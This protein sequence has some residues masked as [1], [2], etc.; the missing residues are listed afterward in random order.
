MNTREPEWPE[1][2]IGEDEEPLLNEI[3]DKL[4]ETSTHEAVDVADYED[5]KGRVLRKMKRRRILYFSVGSGVAAAM[6]G[7]FLLFSGENT[8]LQPE[9]YGR[10]HAEKKGVRNEVVLTSDNGMQTCLDSMVKI[11]NH[12]GKE[13]ALFMASGKKISVEKGR[14]LRVEVP[15]G[16][17]FQLTLADGSE[18][19]LNAGSS[20]EYPASF[21]GAEERRVQLEGEAF[22]EVRRDTVHPF[23]VEFGKRESIRVL[24]TSFN[25]NA[26][27]DSPVHTTTLVSGKI[28]YMAQ[29]IQREVVLCPDQQVCLDCE[30]GGVNVSEVNAALYSVWK[31]GWIWFENERLENLVQ[32]LARRYGIEMYVADRCKDYTFSGKIRY[33]RGMDYI[34][35][36]VTETTDIVCEVENGVVRLK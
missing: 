31:E 3:W 8:K 22:F 29:E 35:K 20:L 34:I 28:K 23:Y 5:V 18:V 12:T 7:I 27:A 24:G 9:I 33:E 16:R 6:A 25:V 36:L 32:R 21:E 17:Q 4:S 11:E 30:A 10:S 26:Y 13:V 15:A 2:E 14:R 19:W 1:Y